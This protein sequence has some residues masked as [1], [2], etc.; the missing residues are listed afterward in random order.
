[1]LEE[2]QDL[3][4]SSPPLSVTFAKID[5]Y[6]IADPTRDEE[7]VMSVRFTIAFD[8][9]DT[10]SS[11]QKSGPGT[12]TSKEINSSVERASKIVKKMRKQLPKR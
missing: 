11:M 10:I 2:T 9:D 1:M 12:L 7:H 6:I 8:S 5:D 4:M 3:K